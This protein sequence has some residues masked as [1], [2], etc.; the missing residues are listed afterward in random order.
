MEAMVC[1][2]SSFFAATPTSTGTR[3]YLP[4]WAT[5]LA[6][7]VTLALAKVIVTSLHIQGFHFQHPIYL[8][9]GQLKF[10]VSLYS[11]K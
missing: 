5:V 7:V 4:L 2:S 11:L 9:A 6:A 3:Q 8:M 1:T 10:S